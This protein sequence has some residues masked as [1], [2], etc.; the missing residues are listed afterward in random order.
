V[1]LDIHAAFPH[2][3]TDSPTVCVDHCI[4]PVVQALW[5][6]GVLTLNSCCGHNAEAP[7]IITHLHDA[8][9]ALTVLREA[10]YPQVRVLAWKL[11]DIGA[12]NNEAEKAR[13]GT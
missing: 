7:S 5:R 1:I 9:R 3:I 4:A 2:V 10:G 8:D 12:M 6:A 11:C 13:N